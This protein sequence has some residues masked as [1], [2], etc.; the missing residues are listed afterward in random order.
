MPIQAFQMTTRQRKVC[1]PTARALLSN[2]GPMQSAE[3]FLFNPMT[4]TKPRREKLPKAWSQPD[5]VLGHTLA[6]IPLR[7]KPSRARLDAV[8]RILEMSEEG[9]HASVINS[10]HFDGSA[11]SVF[12]ALGLIDRDA[13]GRKS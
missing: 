11:S 4:P 8:Q 3:T 10:I 2:S 1:A 13:K 7:T 6:V 5:G 9:I 12:R